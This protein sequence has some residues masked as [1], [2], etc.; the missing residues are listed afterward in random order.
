MKVTSYRV[1]CVK[2]SNRKSHKVRQSNKGGLGRPRVRRIHGKT[3]PKKFT[4][5][6]HVVKKKNFPSKWVE[7]LKDG[8]FPIWKHRTVPWPHCN[9]RSR[10]ERFCPIPRFWEIVETDTID[11]EDAVTLF[12]CTWRCT[13][14]ERWGNVSKPRNL[15]SISF[16]SKWN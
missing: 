9:D 13:A 11:S 4:V 7:K 2:R 10:E 15:T 6:E 14:L 8:V 16:L 1:I 12:P 3:G 5:K